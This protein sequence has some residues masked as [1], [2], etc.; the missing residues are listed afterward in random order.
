MQQIG[1]TRVL[2]LSQREF[3]RLKARRDATPT[4]RS[5][6]RR[7]PIPRPAVRREPIEVCGHRGRRVD[8]NTKRLV[9]CQCLENR[10]PLFFFEAT[11]M[12]AAH[13]CERCKAA[14]YDRSFGTVDA[15]DQV[16]R[17]R[18]KST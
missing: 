8:N 17:N 12:G 11:S 18:L 6:R 2:R 9:C 7:T 10:S 13:L 1:S 16:V 5:K 3:V 15:L 14:A 4:R